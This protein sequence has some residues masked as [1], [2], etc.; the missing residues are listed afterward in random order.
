MEYVERVEKLLSSSLKA[1]LKTAA[2]PLLI[3]RRYALRFK[4]QLG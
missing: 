3:S 4:Q 2:E 1:H